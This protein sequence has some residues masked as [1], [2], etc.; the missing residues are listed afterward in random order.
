MFSHFTGRHG[1]KACSRCDVQGTEFCLVEH[2]RREFME[3][4]CPKDR[5][6]HRGSPDDLLLRHLPGVVAVRH[7][8]DT[9]DRENHE[10]CETRAFC[11]VDEVRTCLRENKTVFFA[12][13]VDTLV[14]ST[15]AS[16]PPRA[17]SKPVPVTRS[18]PRARLRTTVSWPTSRRASAACAP[19][20]PA[21]PAIA[22]L[23]SRSLAFSL[24]ATSVPFRQ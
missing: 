18:T 2:L 4:G 8:V 1:L 16:A 13:S 6:R 15:T 19:T 10:V 23:L 7:V 5:P 17:S 21:P 24:D 9:N 3:L 12:A 22:T 20:A 14:R 11:S